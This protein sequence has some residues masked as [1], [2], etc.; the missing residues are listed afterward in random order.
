MIW[1]I[2]IMSLLNRMNDLG[3]NPL[4][5]K[6][7]YI[8]PSQCRT[9]KKWSF[10]F[11]NVTICKWTYSF[12]L[13]IQSIQMTVQVKTTYYHQLFYTPFVNVSKI[14]LITYYIPTSWINLQLFAIKENRFISLQQKRKI[15][16]S[17]SL[18]TKNRSQLYFIYLP[19]YL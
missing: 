19:M 2:G 3:K 6:N 9:D 17:N 11:Q 15:V 4:R 5:W 1:L 18:L 7:Q 12:P 10:F 13:V 8:N 14:T 16:L